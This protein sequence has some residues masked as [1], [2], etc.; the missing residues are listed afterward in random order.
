VIDIREI[1]GNPQIESDSLA[2]NL[3]AIL[4]KVDNLIEVRHRIIEKIAALPS[5]AA[6][7]EPAKLLI[8]SKLR[9]LQK[10]VVEEAKETMELTVEI[11]TL[12][13]W[14]LRLPDASSLEEVLSET[15]N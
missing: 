13:K 14:G 10:I 2:D 6:R 8:L 7:N 5:K 9:G 4:R 12:E 11:E 15:I 3:L 1:D